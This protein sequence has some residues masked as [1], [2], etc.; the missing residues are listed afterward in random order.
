MGW[1]SPEIL[2][3][4]HNSLKSVVPFTFL[5]LEIIKCP[6]MERGAS[7]WDQDTDDADY[8]LR[9]GIIPKLTVLW[10]TWHSEGPNFCLQNESGKGKAEPCGGG[11]G[12]QDVL[13][14]V[15]CW[16]EWGLQQAQPCHPQPC[17]AASV[18]PSCSLPGAQLE[19]RYAPLISAPACWKSSLS[20]I[21]HLT[22][23]HPNSLFC[24]S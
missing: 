14:P 6:N 13:N 22:Q 21:P 19:P 3:C 24:H 7:A 5:F 23:E 20:S 2:A 18:P 1:N 15:W 8:I 4:C 12:Q 11:E 9:S 16:W 10:K 17:L